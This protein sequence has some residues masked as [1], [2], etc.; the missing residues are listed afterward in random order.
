MRGEDRKQVEM[1][2]AFSM[3]K[4]IAADDPRADG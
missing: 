1:L 4:R 3:E 2:V